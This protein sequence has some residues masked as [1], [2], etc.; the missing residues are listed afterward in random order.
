MGLEANDRGHSKKK[1][2][3]GVIHTTRKSTLPSTDLNQFANFEVGATTGEINQ[4]HMYKS[5]L[6]ALDNGSADLTAISS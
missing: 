1:S 6:T 5:K 2:S 3:N 4:D